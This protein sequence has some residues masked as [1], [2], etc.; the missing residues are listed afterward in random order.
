MPLKESLGG[1]RRSINLLSL[2]SLIRTP[3]LADSF[4][5]YKIVDLLYLYLCL[6][7]FVSVLCQYIGLFCLFFFVGFCIAPVF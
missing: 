5:K 6:Y 2:A 1:A 3:T 7:I 4:Y